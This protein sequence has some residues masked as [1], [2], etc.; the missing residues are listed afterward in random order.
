MKNNIYKH[1]TAASKNV[2]IDKLDE[3][4]EKYRNTH[5]SAIK[6]N[7]IDA[8]LDTYIEYGVK[9]NNKDHKFKVGDH[10]RI[11]K[12]KNIFGKGYT[13]NWLWEVF[14]IKKVKTMYNGHTLLVISTVKRVFK[15]FMKRSCKRKTK[16]NSG[17]KN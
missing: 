17:L 13:P 4:V 2:L 1:K 10:V 6:M 9:D 8:E 15:Q 14:V 11:S 5:H 12:C 3:I 7:P 16:K